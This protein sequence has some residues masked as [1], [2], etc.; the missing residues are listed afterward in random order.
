MKQEKIKIKSLF[1]SDLHLG[2]NNS[3]ANKILELFKKYE[4]KISTIIGNLK[5][6]D[7]LLI[8]NYNILPRFDRYLHYGIIDLEKKSLLELR[9]LKLKRLCK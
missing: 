5:T 3:Q 7:L 1:I 4:F 6:I 9:N 2:N 8:G